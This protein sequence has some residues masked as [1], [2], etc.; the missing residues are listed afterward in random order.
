MRSTGILVIPELMPD[1]YDDV[2]ARSAERP[3]RA[4]RDSCPRPEHKYPPIGG[5][6]G[7]IPLGHAQRSD[8]ELLR[9]LRGLAAGFLARTSVR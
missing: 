9:E 4:R 8:E 6:L 7:G 3:V 1:D 2:I 5:G